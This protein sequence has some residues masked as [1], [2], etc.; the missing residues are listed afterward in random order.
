MITLKKAIKLLSLKDDD[1]IFMCKEHHQP[2]AKFYTIKEIRNKFD[3]KNTMVKKIYPN[4]FRYSND[5]SWEF[6]I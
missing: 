3:M 2:L 5:L 4:H 6:I 1:I